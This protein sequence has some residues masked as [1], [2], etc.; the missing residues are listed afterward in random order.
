MRLR[1]SSL[2]PCARERLAAA[3]TRPVLLCRMAW[4]M[5]TFTPVDP[6]VLEDRWADKP[7]VFALRLAG[8]IGIGEHTIDPRPPVGRHE[9]WH[10][11]GHS[12]L[13]RVWDHRIELTD[14]YGMTRYADVVEVRAGVLTPLA[15]AFAQVFY[16][17]RQRRLNR[18]VAR[19]AL[20]RQE[21]VPA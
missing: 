5:L 9:V 8:R 20:E 7:Y 19:G 3:L 1:C 2:Q 18:L 17:H 21:P 13:I 4:P 15:W 12:E 16:R 10:D 6:P 11:A 14:F